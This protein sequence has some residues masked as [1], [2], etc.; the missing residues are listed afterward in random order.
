MKWGKILEPPIENVKKLSAVLGVSDIVSKLL[1]QRGINNYDIAKDYFRPLWTHLYN[2]FLM[3]DMKIAV[4]RIKEAIEKNEKVMVLGDYDVDGTTSVSLLISYLSDKITDLKPYIPDRYSEGY[5]ISERAIKYANS[6][7]INLIIALDCGIKA[8]EKVRYASSLGIDFIICDHHVPGEKLPD[9]LAVLNPKRRDC[10][11]P[12]NDLCGCG[13]G[14]KLIQ[15]INNHLG[16][17]DSELIIYLDL[18]A[19]SIAADLVPLVGENRTLMFLGLKQLRENP[20]L[21]F[22]ILIKDLKRP[23]NVSDLAFVIAPRIN[24]AGRM[25]HGINAVKLMTSKD[26]KVVLSIARTIEFFNTE[27]KSTEERITKEALQQIKLEEITK[28]FSTVVYHPSWHK[29]VVGI[30]A[31]RLIEYYYRPTIVLTKSE[32]LIV[33]SVRSVYGFDVYEALQACKNNIFQFGGHKYAAGLTL[34]MGQLKPFKE[35]FETYVSENLQPEFKEPEIKY[36]LEV[37][38]ID[39]NS[40]L[41]R[42]IN[43]MRPFGPKN[44]YPVF[45]THNCKDTGASRIVGKDKTHLRLDVLDSNRTYFQGIG[46]G[47]GHMLKKVKETDNFSILY[48]LD[49]NHYSGKVNL[50]LKLRDIKFN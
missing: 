7:G 34:K 31:S 13:I 2:P 3:K 22:K 39:L 49:E 12:F 1:I 35:A 38:F 46:F 37:E 30:V 47:L 25:D 14:F 36:D 32:E 44:M 4:D 50:Q 17:S 48:T 15:A 11:Y 23:V 21:G 19:A 42:I 18:V 24:A 45:V 27:R 33:G 6:E 8:I 40:K 9:A 16:L 20:R 10:N 26:Q 43:Q 5:G 41:L 28:S 29:G